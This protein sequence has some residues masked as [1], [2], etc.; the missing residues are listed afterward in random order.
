MQNE[1]SEKKIPLF[2]IGK[3]AIDAGAHGSAGHM[4]IASSEMNDGPNM[5]NSLKAVGDWMSS[6]FLNS[7]EMHQSLC[8]S[9]QVQRG[10][11]H[12]WLTPRK[13]N[14]TVSKSLPHSS[15]IFGLKEVRVT[16]VQ[17]VTNPQFK[18]DP[19]LVRPVASRQFVPP[20]DLAHVAPVHSAKSKKLGEG[21]H[22]GVTE[23][24]V[25]RHR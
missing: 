5:K 8:E 11:A 20:L 19:Q 9:L 18:F 22:G 15:A 12:A 16:T 17:Q 3:D 7:I 23:D 10:T 25:I 21:A 4:N 24:G 14:S 13:R 1:D 6:M 2:R